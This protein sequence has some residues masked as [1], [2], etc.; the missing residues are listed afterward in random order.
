MTP[1]DLT[2]IEQAAR[3]C[4]VCRTGRRWRSFEVVRREGEESVVLCG[5]CRARFGD[6]PPVP[7]AAA[8]AP[9]AAATEN[10]G[11]R[12]PERRR[13][14]RRPP[15]QKEPEDRLKSA[16]RA[17]PPGGHSIGHIAKT[18]GLNEAKV[19]SRLQRLEASAEVHRVGPSTDLDAAFDRLQAHTSNLRIIRDSDRDRT[20]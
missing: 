4:S 3:R 13:K 20:R 12:S 7:K 15:R 16:L 11:E 19:L 5:A 1:E 18:A 14:R 10:G 6:A 17:L 8:T 2:V 9:A